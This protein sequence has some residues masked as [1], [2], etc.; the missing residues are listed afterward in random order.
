MSKVFEALRRLE[1]QSDGLLVDIN[2]EAKAI[3]QQSAP[4]YY[5]PGEATTAET[6]TAV[7][8]AIPEVHAA[9]PPPPPARVM[10]LRVSVKSPLVPF[11]PIRKSHA[12]AAEE[13]RTIRTKIIQNPAAPR[14]IAVSSVGP[15]DGKTVTSL[16]LAA[17]FALKEN[18][19]VLLVDADMRRG[20]V[21][22]LLGMPDTLG[23]ADVLSGATTLDAAVIRT[24]QLP[25]LHI[26]PSGNRM[27]NPAELLDS[28]RWPE[29][30]VQMRHR[31]DYVIID[32][33]PIGII[34]DFDLL[35]A[36]S[37][38]VVLIARQDHTNR[39]RFL[40]A[41]AAIPPSRLLGVV[42]NCS[43]DW[44]LSRDRSGYVYET[45]PR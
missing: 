8:T 44:F 38:G 28:P 7:L 37:D 17:T 31:F 41:A 30:A 21:G 14:I 6:A 39:S 18:T 22:S 42:L 45:L 25:G 13:Y 23:L 2:A 16:N 20:S 36:Q 26:L 15:Q 29:L 24:Q 4:A 12:R 43:Q 10:S 40:N 35:Q 34:T 5:E 11:I 3:L 33:P 1:A 32:T 27:K 19:R 9:P